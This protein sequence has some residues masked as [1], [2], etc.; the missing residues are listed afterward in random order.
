MARS[1]KGRNK[2]GRER[3]KAIMR[4]N[5]KIKHKLFKTCS[6][7]KL[8]TYMDIMNDELQAIIDSI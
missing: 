3:R 1:R 2:R 6:R 5:S 4:L 8:R 7:L